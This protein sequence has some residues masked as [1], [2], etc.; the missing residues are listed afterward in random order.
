MSVVTLWAPSCQNWLLQEG[1]LSVMGRIFLLLSVIKPG[2]L[3]F[4]VIFEIKVNCY[5][6]LQCILDTK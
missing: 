1:L 4:T 5:K 2:I 3:M 6:T